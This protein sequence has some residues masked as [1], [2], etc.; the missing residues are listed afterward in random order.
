MNCMCKS[1]HRDH[2]S[3]S[4]NWLTIDEL[5]EAVNVPSRIREAGILE[6]WRVMDELILNLVLEVEQLRKDHETAKQKFLTKTMQYADMIPLIQAH[7]FL[8]AR[9]FTAHRL[10]KCLE[11]HQTTPVYPQAYAYSKQ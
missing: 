8:E 1:P 7:A 3:N 10:R 9:K 6:E 11:E 4:D 2:I 5:Q